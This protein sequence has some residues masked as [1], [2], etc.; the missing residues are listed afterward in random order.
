[1]NPICLVH[2]AFRNRRYLPDLGVDG[3][4]DEATIEG[5]KVRVA[6]LT[7]GIRSFTQS[8]YIFVRSAQARKYLN[9]EPDFGS[10]LLVKTDPQ[11]WASKKFSRNFCD[12]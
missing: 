8:P 9:V 7:E 12:N 4:G 5:F 2:A 11:P 3:V 6:G 1:M 10:F